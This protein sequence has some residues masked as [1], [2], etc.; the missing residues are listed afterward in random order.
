MYKPLLGFKNEPRL[1]NCI[2]AFKEHPD[3]LDEIKKFYLLIKFGESGEPED[4]HL[5]A[6]TTWKS[7]DFIH[8][9]HR[10]E[11]KHFE[12]P[13]QNGD[14][15]DGRDF[16]GQFAIIPKDRA[17]KIISFQRH[18][19]DVKE[20]DNINDIPARTPKTSKLLWHGGNLDS[21]KT[22]VVTYFT[23][24]KEM[25]ESYVDMSSDRFGEGS[26]EERDINIHNPAPWEIIKNVAQDFGFDEDEVD[27]YT[28]ASIF[29]AELFGE[30]PVARLVNN[31]RSKGYD[32]AIL[33]DIGYGVS[34]QAKAYIVF[35]YK[36]N[37]MKRSKLMGNKKAGPTLYKELERV[38]EEIHK[39][40]KWDHIKDEMDSTI[41][42]NN[43][44][45]SYNLYTKD[46]V[47]VFHVVVYEKD[48]VRQIFTG[49]ET[50]SGY[51]DINKYG[52]DNMDKLVR[53]NAKI[54]TDK[55][56]V[57]AAP[58]E[59]SVEFMDNDKKFLKD[60]GIQAK[61]ASDKKSGLEAV[62]LI[63]NALEAA[64]M[65]RKSSFNGGELTG[66]TSTFG[67]TGFSVRK[68]S[69]SVVNWHIVISGKPLLK[70][71]K[72]YS[73]NEDGERESNGEEPVNPDSLLPRIKKV[74]QDLGLD[75]TNLGCSGYQTMWDD[76]V[77]YDITTKWPEWLLKDDKKTRRSSL[78]KNR[79]AGIELDWDPQTRREVGKEEARASSKI[80]R[81]LKTYVEQ[82]KSDLIQNGISLGKA[83]SGKSIKDLFSSSDY[84]ERS[85]GNKL[86]SSV[87]QFL[88][89]YPEKE[90]NFF[91][92]NYGANITDILSTVDK[93]SAHNPQ[94]YDIKLDGDSKITPEMKEAV[95]GPNAWDGFGK[96]T[97]APDRDQIREMF[98]EKYSNNI[99]SVEMN[100]DDQ[101][102]DILNSVINIVYS[103]PEY[104]GFFEEDNRTQSD[105]DDFFYFESPISQQQVEAINNKFLEEQK[106]LGSNRSEP[107]IQLSLISFEDLP[108]SVSSYIVNHD[109]KKYL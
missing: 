2:K 84:T 3:L 87:D 106:K 86:R 89:K 83:L 44:G 30:G 33:D 104:Q 14:A 78:I 62:T 17:L 24:N 54:A 102:L 70:Y 23:D 40:L 50:G 49:F 95:L 81:D 90:Q 47:V 77:D 94:E 107:L 103:L 100:A 52:M 28:P 91:K 18:W 88:K 12:D 66:W 56:G 6:Q 4:R 39:Y 46:G 20:Y 26:L 9:T 109:W 105:K 8:F 19:A 10:I 55:Y 51:K 32:G 75:V 71:K 64:G 57:E 74:F 53:D 25:A 36:D 98:Q 80:Y 92:E 72:V 59:K 13:Y 60:L 99:L 82:L 5:I 7:G 48:G 79:E 29:D 45:A 42:E 15:P 96:G 65:P 16:E 27:N 37:E 21:S 31:L 67:S 41:D 76:D 85:L 69:D 68:V 73:W 93:T 34:I 1:S 108:E 61:K 97:E 43:V 22:P 38:K 58:V 63:K 101:E 11:G 35:N